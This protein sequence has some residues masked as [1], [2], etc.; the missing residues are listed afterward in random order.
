[1]LTTVEPTALNED[2]TQAAGD[3]AR[4]LHHAL[5]S[6]DGMICLRA[7]DDHEVIVPTEAFRLFV[8]LL[9]MLANGDG[10]VV[11]PEHAEVST[12]QA[13]DM[14]N[15]SRPFV[16]KLIEER[17]LPARKVGAHRRILLADLIAYK[18]QD[19]AEREAVMSE[20]AAESQRLGFEY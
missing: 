14:L 20:L 16:V 5:Q 1:M 9:T 19:E 17:K 2:Q 13:A 10:V 6:A 12:Q 7:N 18:R 15:V 8:D 11:M 3:A 4:A